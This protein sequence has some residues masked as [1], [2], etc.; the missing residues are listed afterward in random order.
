MVVGYFMAEKNET[1]KITPK[2]LEAGTAAAASFFAWELSDPETL[3]ASVFSAMLAARV[4]DMIGTGM[5]AA[6]Y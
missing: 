3:V 4:G 6:L 2:M 5:S 1:V